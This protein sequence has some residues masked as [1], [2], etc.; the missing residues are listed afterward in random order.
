MKDAIAMKTP[1]SRIDRFNVFQRELEGG[2]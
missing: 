1:L 2:Q